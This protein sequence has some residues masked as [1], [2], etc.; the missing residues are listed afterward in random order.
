MFSDKSLKGRKKKHRKKVIEEILSSISLPLLCSR[1]D[2][3]GVTPE[4][5]V[6]LNHSAASKFQSPEKIGGQYFLNPF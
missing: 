5:L 4:K 3:D 2:S 1:V 6:P